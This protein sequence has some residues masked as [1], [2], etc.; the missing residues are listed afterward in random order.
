MYLENI[1]KGK[2]LD[3]FYL[4]TNIILLGDAIVTT[5]KKK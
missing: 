2:Q 3:I 1:Y 5:L 4:K